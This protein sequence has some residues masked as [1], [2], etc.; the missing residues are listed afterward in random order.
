M[1]CEVGD[2]LLVS[3]RWLSHVK[4]SWSWCH[5]NVSMRLRAAASAIQACNSTPRRSSR[6]PPSWSDAARAIL[7]SPP[8]SQGLSRSIFCRMYSHRATLSKEEHAGHRCVH[9]SSA[10]RRN[11][12]LSHR[13]QCC[14][15]QRWQFH[16]NPKGLPGSWEH[17]R[18]QQQ[19]L[20]KICL[21][22][23]FV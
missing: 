2:W 16:H 21:C 8:T 1:R 17:V 4:A 18:H 20:W 9:Y 22:S 3:I 12:Y 5:S 15:I 19:E 13:L 7:K 14:V 23:R 11:D 10:I 6:A